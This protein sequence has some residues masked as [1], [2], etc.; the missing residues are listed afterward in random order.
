MLTVCG[1]LDAEKEAEKQHKKN[2]AVLRAYKMKDP[3]FNDKMEKVRHS[4]GSN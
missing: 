4:D 3:D 1:S 2:K